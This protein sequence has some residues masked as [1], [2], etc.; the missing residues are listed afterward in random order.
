[1]QTDSKKYYLTCQETGHQTEV[2]KEIYEQYIA[3]WDRAW[4]AC[5][6]KVEGIGRMVLYGTG[7]EI[8]KDDLESLFYEANQK[9][10]E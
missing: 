4:E 2:P 10:L 3:A 1:M 8:M 9:R 7:G 6:P 5:Q